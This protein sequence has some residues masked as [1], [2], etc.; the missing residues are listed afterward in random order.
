MNHHTYE[1]PVLSTRD[2][3]VTSFSALSVI[4]YNMGTCPLWTCWVISIL[5]IYVAMLL[6]YWI[7]FFCYKC[8]LH[9]TED[10]HL[11]CHKRFLSVSH[12]FVVLSA[13]FLEIYT[14]KLSTRPEDL[15]EQQ[16]WCLWFNEKWN[17]SHSRTACC[18][19]AAVCVAPFIHYSPYNIHHIP[20]PTP[21]T[22]PT[23]TPLRC[24]A[25]KMMFC[26]K[27]SCQRS[28]WWENTTGL[29]L[30]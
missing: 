16:G 23:F 7:F 6:Y 3:W 17:S 14:T 20:P 10:W 25:I 1:H 2:I 21:P 26:F 18:L 12:S 22:L 5:Y 27:L 29:L 24:T 9:C 8:Y 4:C 11:L 15:R 28:K 30:S 19:T 13:R